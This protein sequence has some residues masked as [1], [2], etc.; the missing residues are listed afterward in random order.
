[1]TDYI[2]S[3]LTKNSVATTTISKQQNKGNNKSMLQKIRRE[4]A[5]E[6]QT[7]LGQELSIK[8]IADFIQR[9]IKAGW[10]SQESAEPNEKM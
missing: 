4:Q 2:K 5:I 8:D 9:D 1:M 6:D 3:L 7:Y 10:K